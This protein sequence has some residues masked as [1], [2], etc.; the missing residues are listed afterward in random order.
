MHQYVDVLLLKG[1]QTLYFPVLIVIQKRFFFLNI[2]HMSLV[3]CL[4]VSF[5]LTLTLTGLPSQLSLA[6]VGY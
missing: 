6:L 1:F 5:C 2:F 4:G 3:K